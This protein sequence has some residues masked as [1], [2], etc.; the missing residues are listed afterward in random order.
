VAV[1]TRGLYNSLAYAA[2]L[3]IIGRKMGD[4][5][6]EEQTPFMEVREKDSG[7]DTFHSGKL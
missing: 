6:N 4:A 5:I 3:Y 7:I 2:D 1:P